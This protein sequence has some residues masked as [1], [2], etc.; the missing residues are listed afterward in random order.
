M[1]L[2]GMEIAAKSNCGTLIHIVMNNGAHE[3]VGGMPVAGGKMDL[4]AYARAAGYES[5]CTVQD[6]AELRETLR[7]IN[8][9]NGVRFLEIRVALGARADLGRPTTTPRDN[10][11]ALKEYLV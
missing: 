2:G 6:E 5:V 1:H 9:I 3:S 10:L 4:T 8:R 7:Q 11:R